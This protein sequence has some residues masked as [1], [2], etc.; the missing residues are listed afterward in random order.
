LPLK[1]LEDFITTEFK[2]KAKNYLSRHPKDENT[3]EWLALMRHYGAPTRLLDWSRSP[4]VATFFAAADARP[5]GAL[6]VWC[7]DLLALQTRAKYLLGPPGTAADLQYF[8][9]G[10][11]QNISQRDRPALVIQIE[12]HDM[13]ERL[14]VQQGLFLV[15]NQ[16][17]Y[18]FER[19]LTFMLYPYR[20]TLSENLEQAVAVKLVIPCN[21]RH[22]VLYALERM[23]IGWASLVPGLDGFA[24]SLETLCKIIG[25]GQ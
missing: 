5:P 8:E 18:P 23:N 7:L 24:R 14:V 1:A 2:R 25:R 17:Q 12:P 22:E 3:L 21:L 9:V 10:Y 6:A 4:F 11:E 16:T 13:N 19:A 20:H 15:S